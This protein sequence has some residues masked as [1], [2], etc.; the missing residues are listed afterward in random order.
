MSALH[1]E[2]MKAISILGS[3]G[4]IGC[5]TL[6]VVEF[7]GDFRVVALGAGGNIGKLAEQIEQFQPELVAVKDETC[8]E[9]LLR[10]ISNFKFQIPKILIG[11]A[12][13]IAV[14]THDEAETVVSATVGAVGFVPTLR[15]LARVRALPRARA[16]RQLPAPASQRR[17]PCAT[18]PLPA[19]R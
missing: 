6:K 11:E 2:F 14:A 18:R 17:L 5:N 15:A 1:D 19:T 4:S 3:T 16:P 12:G 8:A 10:K 9:E 7:L 13:L